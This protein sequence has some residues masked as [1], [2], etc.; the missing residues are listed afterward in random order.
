MHVYALELA[1]KLSGGLGWI[2]G[3][4]SWLG[5]LLLSFFYVFHFF[6]ICLN[7]SLV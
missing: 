2:A 7:S 6:S 4:S 3:P 5:G 1:A